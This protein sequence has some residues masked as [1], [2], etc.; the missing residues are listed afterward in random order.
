MAG[1]SLERTS[2]GKPRFGGCVGIRDFEFLGK[3][4]EGTF[5]YVS[6]GVLFFMVCRGHAETLQRGVQS[7]IQEGCLRRRVEE[8]PHA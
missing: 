8:D 6:S 5:G 7:E 2:D 4:G 1:A 3:L